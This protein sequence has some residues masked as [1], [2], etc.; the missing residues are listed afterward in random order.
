MW[1]PVNTLCAHILLG[2]KQRWRGREGDVAEGH[3]HWL[4][5]AFCKY[6]SLL[7]EWTAADVIGFARRKG[8]LSMVSP[9]E[10]EVTLRPKTFS[11]LL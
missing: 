10:L 8:R 1:S 9:F 11:L 5:K 7:V 2:V 4:W 3:L 6:L